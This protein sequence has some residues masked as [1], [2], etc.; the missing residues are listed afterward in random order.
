MVDD[1]MGESTLEWVA[2][3]GRNANEGKGFR[4]IMG[5]G[6]ECI[7]TETIE[8]SLVKIPPI[9]QDLS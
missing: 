4:D 7:V 8:T 3:W 9:C 5:K 1:A 6:K 2:I